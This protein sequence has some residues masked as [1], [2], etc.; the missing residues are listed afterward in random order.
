MRYGPLTYIKD[1]WTPRPPVQNADLSGEVVFVTG[2]N[3]GLGY[4]AAK[5]FALMGATVIMGCRS[6]ER[7]EAAVQRLLEETGLRYEAAQ[8]SLVDLADFKSVSTCADGVQTDHSRLDI[9][10]LNAGLVS[11]KYVPSVDGLET[12]LQTNAIAQPLLAL[13]LLPLMA[14][15]AKEHEKTARVVTVSSEG[16]YWC[17]VEELDDL[18]ARPK[19]SIFDTLSD[20]DYCLATPNRLAKHRYH[21]TK[22]FNVLFTRALAKRLPAPCCITPVAIIPGHCRSSILQPIAEDGGTL[23]SWALRLFRFLM[24]Y[25]T[26]EGSRQL[27]YGALGERGNDDA[28]HGQVTIS[29]KNTE[30]SDFAISPQGQEL[31]DRY[32]SELL[33]LLAKSDSKIPRIL[34]EFGL[35]E[36]KAV[37]IEKY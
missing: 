36:D 18:L 3:T 10:V 32:W 7:G 17:D 5:H 33:D 21:Q 31:E 2:A 16:H 27:V 34:E 4:E 1:Q 19:G 13:R 23:V 29:S 12:V 6:K 30:P 20:K 11:P 9:L 35:R 37:E 26:E 24:A 14:R 22:L 28:I 8:L 15:T 25:T